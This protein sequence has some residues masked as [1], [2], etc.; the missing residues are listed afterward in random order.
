MKLGDTI[1]S[2]DFKGEKHVPVIEAPA[3]VKAGEAFQ[4]EVS[5]GKEIAHPNKAEHYIGWIKLFFTP[6]GGKFAIEV[7]DFDFAVHGDSMNPDKPGPVFAE[8]FGVT[9][10]KLAKAGTLTALS[11]CNLHGLWESSKEIA[12]E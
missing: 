9:K 1:Q 10:I 6:E 5:V 2:G 11:Y 4:V 8:P 3:K 7:A 12:V